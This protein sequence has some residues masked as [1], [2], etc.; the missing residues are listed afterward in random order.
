M[1][2]AKPVVFGEANAALRFDSLH[3]RVQAERLDQVRPLTV[4]Y[5][6]DHRAHNILGDKIA[7]KQSIDRVAKPRTIGLVMQHL[8]YAAQIRDRADGNIRQ[9]NPNFAALSCLFALA[10]CRQHRK[11]S[12]RSAQQI[13]CGQDMVDWF[14]ASPCHH[15]I[16]HSVINGVIQRRCAISPAHDPYGYEIGASFRQFGMR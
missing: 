15:G 10:N 4:C 3:L 13:P 7:P 6:H 8:G 16:A 12:I 11:C 5:N 9:G 14:W 1:L 2:K